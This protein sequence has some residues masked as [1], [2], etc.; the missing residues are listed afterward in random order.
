MGYKAR[1]VFDA[2]QRLKGCTPQLLGAWHLGRLTEAIKFCTLSGSRQATVGGGRVV[3]LGQD[4]QVS[5][6]EPDELLSVPAGQYRRGFGCRVMGSIAHGDEGARVE[7]QGQR[8]KGGCWGNRIPGRGGKEA[9][10]SVPV[11]VSP[12]TWMVDS[13]PWQHA[14]IM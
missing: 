1:Q 13:S 8:D 6:P 10:G 5:R 3:P 12:C 11:I 14:A 7:R 2:V 4:H 9:G